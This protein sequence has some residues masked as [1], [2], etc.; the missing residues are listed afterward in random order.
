[1]ALIVWIVEEK[2][3]ARNIAI[4]RMI[5]QILANPYG[6]SGWVLSSWNLQY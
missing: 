2:A 1:M 3:L 4:W 5:L 6:I